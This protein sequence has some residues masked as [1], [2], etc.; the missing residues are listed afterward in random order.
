MVRY[1]FCCGDRSHIQLPLALSVAAL[2]VGVVTAP[3]RTL[4]V[5]LAGGSLSCLPALACASRRAVALAAVTLRADHEEDL[6]APAAKQPVAVAKFDDRRFLLSALDRRVARCHPP[7]YA[8]RMSR[9]C[10]ARRGGP[11]CSAKNLALGLR[12]LCLDGV[13][14]LLHAPCVPSAGSHAAHHASYPQFSTTAFSHRAWR[15][16][17]TPQNKIH[18]LHNW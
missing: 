9:T 3:K 13:R 4:L 14:L 17:A 2:A 15:R 12:F 7:R 1:V 11:G 16:Q 10:D 6:A 18:L 5:A 8:S